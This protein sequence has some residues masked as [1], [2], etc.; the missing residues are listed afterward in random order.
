VRRKPTK[1]KKFENESTAAPETASP[2]GSPR[3][4]TVDPIELPIPP[5]TSSHLDQSIQSNIYDPTTFNPIASTSSFV[6]DPIPTASSHPQDPVFIPNFDSFQ[7]VSLNHAP[8][9]LSVSPD[10]AQHLFRVFRQTPQHQH[11]LFVT[12]TLDRTLKTLNWQVDL[13]PSHSHV[14]AY[15]IFAVASLLSHH[16]SILDPFCVNFGGA[17]PSNFDEVLKHLPDLRKFG[18]LRLEACQMYRQEAIRRAKESDILFVASEE[19]AT[20]CHLLYWLESIG[21]SPT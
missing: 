7:L 5:T 2:S 8:T 9:R 20:A 16:T 12:Y 10:L 21:E 17:C 19:A 18:K 14:L 4:S 1:R 11:P 3:A 15:C 6:H 13:L